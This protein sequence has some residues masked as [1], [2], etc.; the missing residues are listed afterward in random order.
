[1]EIMSLVSVCHSQIPIIPANGPLAGKWYLVLGKITMA[2]PYT[3]I[4]MEMATHVPAWFSVEFSTLILSYSTSN[5]SA[6]FH[7]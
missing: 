6:L 3:V 2:V 7:A 5:R 4:P 1:M